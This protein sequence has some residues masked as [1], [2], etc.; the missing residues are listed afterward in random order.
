LTDSDAPTISTSYTFASADV[1]TGQYFGLR[2]LNRNDAAG[3]AFAGRTILDVDFDNFN[4][5]P[6]PSSMALVLTVGLLPLLRR[7]RRG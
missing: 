7:R 1:L 5:I 6:E 2:T 4:A 3:S